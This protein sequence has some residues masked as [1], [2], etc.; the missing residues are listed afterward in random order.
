MKG[1]DKTRR[2]GFLAALALFAVLLTAFV[3]YLI[4]VGSD[5]VRVSLPQR[6]WLLA[7]ECEDSTETAVTGDVYLSGGAGY[8]YEADGV[9]AAVLAC[10]YSEATAKSVC[11][12]MSE[13]GMETFVAPLTPRE[14]ELN[15]AVVYEAER[16]YANAKTVDSCA[17]ILYNAAN[18][19]ERCELSQDEARAALKGVVASLNGLCE[20]NAGSFY[21]LWN[22]E[23]QRAAKRGTEIAQGI[24]FAKDFRYLQ[25]Q[26]CVL[27]SSAADYFA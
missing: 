15:G 13:K 10:Y 5:Y 14:F 8:L 21:G 11:G 16:V 3:V 18:G 22:A 7:K 26:L 24:L 9:S 4:R 2:G 6:Y 12:T 17:K 1:F 19:L 20:G 23:L 25:V 27:V